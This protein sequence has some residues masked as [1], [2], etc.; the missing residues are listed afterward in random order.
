MNNIVGSNFIV[1]FDKIYSCES[2]KQHPEPK[3]NIAA[4]FFSSQFKPSLSG[5]HN[6]FL[7]THNRVAIKV[8]GLKLTVNH[9]NS[10]KICCENSCFYN[11]I[12]LHLFA[13]M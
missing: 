3:K 10:Y 6:W 13:E 2:H 7:C 12:V 5:G 1:R 4:V 9:F 11:I 8:V